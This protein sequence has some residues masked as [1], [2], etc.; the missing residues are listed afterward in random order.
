V[1]EDQKR[2]LGYDGETAGDPVAMRDDPPIARE[3][4]DRECYASCQ[5]DGGR[6]TDIKRAQQAQQERPKTEE[7]TQKSV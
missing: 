3:E 5:K 6:A 4:S 7:K 1:D 2:T